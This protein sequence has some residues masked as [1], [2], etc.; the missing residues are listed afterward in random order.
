MSSLL[1]HDE[2]SVFPEAQEDSPAA[3]IGDSGKEAR[4][5]LGSILLFAS[6]DTSLV[7]QEES[8]PRRGLHKKLSSLTPR[9]ES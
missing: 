6:S 5:V 4:S 3:E 2:T 9:S 8:K 1:I 7:A